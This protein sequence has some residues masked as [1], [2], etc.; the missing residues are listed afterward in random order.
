MGFWIFIANF[1][2]KIRK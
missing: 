1:R 2:S